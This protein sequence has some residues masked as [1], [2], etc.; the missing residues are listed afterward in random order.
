[1]WYHSGSPSLLPDEE[2]SS[3]L[4]RLNGTLKRLEIEVLNISSIVV[5]KVDLALSNVV[6]E[7]STTSLLTR[8]ENLEKI[9][10]ANQ[11]Q[12]T[13]LA[14]SVEKLTTT[15]A[16]HGT[17]GLGEISNDT[18]T[19]AVH[20]HPMF[21]H[22]AD[23]LTALKS[24]VVKAA[25]L[26][27]I[28]Q[29]V[30]ENNMILKVVDTSTKAITTSVSNIS[31]QLNTSIGNSDNEISQL[32][33]NSDE[34]LKM[35]LSMQTSLENL[36]KNN[37]PPSDTTGRAR[38]SSQ[39]TSSA[40]QPPSPAQPPKRKG[41]MFTSTLAQDTD[42]KRLEGN[43]NCD[44]TVI[45]TLHIEKTPAAEDPES[46]LQNMVKE[47]LS[48]KTGFNFVIIASGSSD[49]TSMDTI[50][51]T[52]VPLYEQVKSQAGLLCDTA[53]SITQD[54]GVDVFL[55]ENPPR[56]D[57]TP[58]DP[59]A[60]KQKLNKYSNSLLST[61]LGLT[62]RVFIVEQGS[63]A[64]SSPRARSDLYQSDGVHLTTKG[65]YYHSSNLITAM[66]ELYP[67]TKH[68]VPAED[69][70]RGAGRGCQSGYHS[71]G[72]DRERGGDGRQQRQRDNRGHGGWRHQ[73]RGERYR[74]QPSDNYSDN[75]GWRGGQRG[76]GWDREQ[77]QATP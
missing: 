65:L 73:N 68:I 62:P 77:I 15:I 66:Q 18:L 59:A 14:Q 1:M 4:G 54:M 46:Y 76:G 23:T 26:D 10:K 19:K 39:S 22:I 38:V 45:P 7:A 36:V 47:N 48:G 21:S 34:S 58:S 52:P 32:R 24:D 40:P 50:N 25:D 64:R 20:S 43:L 5:D 49:I 53:Q 55:V 75:R 44:I 2:E 42:M 31:D 13:N 9:L 51:G 74:D 28:G 6:P 56:Y 8:V 3:D 16:A 67:D 17:A 60:M 70:E 69:N 12:F 30:A 29:Q 61:T 71:P 33:K 41:L 27:S 35:F 63:L 57:P 72:R 11:E 37:T